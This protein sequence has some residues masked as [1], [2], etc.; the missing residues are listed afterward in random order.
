MRFGS[1]PRVKFQPKSLPSRLCY[2]SNVVADLNFKFYC[3]WLMILLPM[4]DSLTALACQSDPL[5]DS[6]F[7]IKAQFDVKPVTLYIILDTLFGTKGVIIKK[8]MS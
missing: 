6:W 3:Y 8:V 2:S 7:E 4:E 1:K 5:T